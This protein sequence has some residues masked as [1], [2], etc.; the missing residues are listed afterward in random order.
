MLI[1]KSK[2]QIKPTSNTKHQIGLMDRY[3]KGSCKHMNKNNLLG[4]VPIPLLNE[5]MEE[6][7]E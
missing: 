1:T 6:S 3:D 5:A 2:S 7:L 4:F